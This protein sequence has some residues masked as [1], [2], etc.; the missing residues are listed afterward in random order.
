[1]KLNRKFLAMGLALSFAFLGLINPSNSYASNINKN[2]SFYRS[3][4]TRSDYLAL[5]D[6][7]RV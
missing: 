1:M 7:Q 5:S 4:K 6:S 3:A 2:S